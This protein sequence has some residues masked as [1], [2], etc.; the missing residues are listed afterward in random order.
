MLIKFII[1][2]FC[3][4][5]FPTIASDLIAINIALKP[6]KEVEDDIKK[7]NSK[8]FKE[9]TGFQF[10]QTHFPHLTLVQ[11]VIKKS[12]FSAVR[13]AIKKQRFKVIDLKPSRFV[14][15]DIEKESSLK[16]LSL[17]FE[18][19]EKIVNLQREILSKIKNYST[20]DQT[21][22][23]FYDPRTVQPQFVK[24]T[25]EFL[26]DSTGSKF[27]PHVTLGIVSKDFKVGEVPNRKAKFE[28]IQI[29]QIGRYGTARKKL[30]EK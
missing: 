26:E 3:I 27:E 10:D 21:T 14:L 29:Y 19:N 12:D 20:K 16:V 2:V 4:I 6:A 28:S 13:N 11:I 25:A 22:E 30:E 24:Y 8:T 17:E 23:A 7:I 18:Q 5:S 15:D 1:L 9:P